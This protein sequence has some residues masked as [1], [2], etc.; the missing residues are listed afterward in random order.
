MSRLGVSLSSDAAGDSAAAGFFSP[1]LLAGEGRPEL[2]A[3]A[4]PALGDEADDE[5]GNAPDDDGPAG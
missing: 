3:R 4:G 5:P 2:V 1:G